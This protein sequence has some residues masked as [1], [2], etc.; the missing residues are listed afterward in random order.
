MKASDGRSAVRVTIDYIRACQTARAAG[1]AVYLTTDPEWLLDVAINRRAG[2]AEDRHSRDIA[3]PIRGKLPR[4]A[5][6]DAQR[7]LRLIADEVNSPRLIVRE[8]RLGE[9]KRYLTRK[10]PGRFTSPGDET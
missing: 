10:L 1:F 6:G 3:Q 9:W 4:F 7:H 2:W 8:T 5:S